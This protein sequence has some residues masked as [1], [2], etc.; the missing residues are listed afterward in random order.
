M[1]MPVVGIDNRGGSSRRVSNRLPGKA[2]DKWASEASAKRI[3][4]RE[5]VQHLY[6]LQTPPIC[7]EEATSTRLVLSDTCGGE[8]IVATEHVPI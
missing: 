5:R 6:N 4:G 3:C 1:G 2:M 7:H 8:S